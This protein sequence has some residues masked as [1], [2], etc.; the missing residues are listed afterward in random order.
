[1]VL[2]EEFKNQSIDNECGTYEIYKVKKSEI[3]AYNVLPSTVRDI[4]I[5]TYA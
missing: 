3:G 1:M 5:S 4:L 2:G